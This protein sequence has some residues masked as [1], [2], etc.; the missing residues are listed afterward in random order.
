MIVAAGSGSR[1]GST[2]P[3]QFHAMGDRKVIDWSIHAFSGVPQIQ[4]LVVVLPCDEGSWK[5]YWDPPAGVKLVPGGR[6]RQ[7]SVLRGLES[8]GPVTHV[9]V[10]DAARPFVS[11][12]LIQ[13]VIEGTR[14]CGA[15]VPVTAVRDTVKEVTGDF[16]IVGTVARDTL[17][18]SQ[19]PQGF[20]VDLLSE[21]L[22]TASDVTD[23]ASA[24]E[25]AGMRVIAVDG[26]PL[27][28]KLT[29]PEDLKLMEAYI[30]SR[31]Q[32]RSAIGLDFHPFEEGRV[33]ILGGCRI[34]G[35]SGLSGHSDGDAVLHAVADALLSAARLGDIG[36]HFPPEDEKWKDADS[37]QLLRR[38]VELI[39]REGWVIS[40]IDITVISTHPSIRTLR[41][42]MLRTIADILGVEPERVWIKGTTTNTLGDI[43]KGLGLGCMALASIERIAVPDGI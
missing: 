6:R 32:I 31:R 34:E 4:E 19:T 2:V 12:A 9:L 28:M 42:E 11:P 16:F 30:G 15:A 39:S 26:D 24:L 29:D 17:G 14:I 7:D 40:Q 36:F 38:I 8:L 20:R 18:L 23:E 10:H 3:K 41:E 21:A 37:G 25:Q 13:R 27:N 35:E 1:L 33:L 5:P 22:T 43:G